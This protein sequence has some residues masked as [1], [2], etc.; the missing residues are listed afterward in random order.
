MTVTLS[1]GD[2][3]GS[4]VASTS[5]RVDGGG[6][7]SGTSV[8]VAAPADHSNDG[9][10]TIDYY[11]VDNVGNT[12]A[13]RHATV[14]IDTQPPSGTPADPGS[15]L[16]GT[17]V[18]SDPS[19]SDPGAGVASVAFQYSP[20]GA[21]TWTTIGTPVSA[22]WAVLFDTTAVADGQVDLREVISDAAAPANVTT[23]DLP[24]PK[25][26]DNTPPSSASVT[27]P[28]PGVHA[29]GVVTLGG[30]ASDATSGI[31]QMVFKV[32]GT[33][34][35][36]ATGTPASVTWDSTSTPDGPVSVTVEAKDVAGNG[37]TVSSA[38]TIVVDNHPPTVTLADPGAAVRGTVSL[39]TTTSADTIQV[40]FE[41]SPAGAGTWTT[42]AVDNTPPFTANLDTT[43]LADGLYDL[44]AVATD[45]AN[46]VTSNVVTTRVDN[47]AP[48]GSVTAPT[49]GSTVGGP[50][51]T[52]KANAADS[53]SGVATV[54]F[55]VDGTT[56]GT[57]SSAPWT[58]AWDPSS[59]PSGA[60]TIDAVVTDAAGN[61]FTTAGVPSRSTRR[62]RA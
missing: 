4:G 40:T 53:G 61:T 10:H 5:Y 16:A 15:V 57:A 38:R 25:L 1:P 39:T 17:V 41:R 18:L 2:G 47:T 22:P 36:T 60:H 48:T 28:A 32:N 56:V 62:R 12:E 6:W 49:A 51:V 19:P 23:V 52:L 20:H 58:L 43:L 21:G 11:S 14:T 54:Q 7:Q 35:G 31:G 44:H 46:V 37:P 24:G 9:A 50:S 27:A 26:I 8:V 59:T 42:I 55:R 34:V 13:V 3:S 33:V 30:A 45:G 29:G